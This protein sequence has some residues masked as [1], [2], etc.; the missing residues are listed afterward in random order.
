MY[1]QK[2]IWSTRVEYLVLVPKGLEGGPDARR[3]PH[4]GAT[5]DRLDVLFTDRKTGDEALSGQKKI[6]PSFHVSKG[7]NFVIDFC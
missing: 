3:L 6:N 4:V 7:N 5:L 1:F 2:E